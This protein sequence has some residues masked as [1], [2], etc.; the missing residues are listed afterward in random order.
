MNVV[1]A[2]FLFGLVW[3]IGAYVTYMISA[4]VLE[5]D[6]AGVVMGIFFPFSLIII[7]CFMLVIPLLEF[8]SGSSSD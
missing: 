4:Q 8:S 1:L 3:M 7:P 6:L 5:S 2:I